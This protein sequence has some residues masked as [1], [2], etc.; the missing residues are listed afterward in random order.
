MSK[1]AKKK[2]DR[3]SAKTRKPKTARAKPKGRLLTLDGTIG[4]ELER[5]VEQMMELLGGA[6]N[7]TGCSKW[8][9]SNTFYELRM[10][11]AK[12]LAPPPR[13][14][15]LL[16]AADLFFRLRWEIRPALEEGYTVLAAPYLETAVAFGLAA[17]ISKEWLDELFSFAPKPEACFRIKEKAKVKGKRKNKD[18]DG[19]PAA[20]GFVEFGEKSLAASFPNLDAAELRR[21][22]LAHF[23]NLEAQGDIKRLGKKLPKTL[24]KK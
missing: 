18:K 16:Y 24:A 8:D 23:D 17:G 10:G 9:A 6:S 21:R 15:L 19:R 20:G 2:K 3:S 5:G 7:S 11:K 13:A 1:P 22:T 12:R 14:L 4:R